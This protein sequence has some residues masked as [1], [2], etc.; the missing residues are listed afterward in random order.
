MRFV[1]PDNYV[2]SPS[3]PWF[4][5]FFVLN[6]MAAQVVEEQVLEHDPLV[7]V[8][9]LRGVTLEHGY[10]Y[11]NVSKLQNMLLETA[12]NAPE[13]EAKELYDVL[14]E[15]VEDIV[16]GRSSIANRLDTIKEAL[17][18]V[19]NQELET[20]HVVHGYK[21]PTLSKLC[22]CTPLAFL[23][24]NF[25]ARINSVYSEDKL[26]RQ[27][28]PPAALDALVDIV[29]W[30]H[31]RGIDMNP[32]YYFNCEIMADML[33][34]PLDSFT[35]VMRPRDGHLATLVQW[36]QVVDQFELFGMTLS[37]KA[38]QRMKTARSTLDPVFRAERA[39]QARQARLLQAA[40]V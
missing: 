23:F 6:T 40:P 37:S 17:A 13:N 25:H 19:S 26:R 32:G 8:E 36:V 14:H 34:C 7:L 24:G 12:Y 18:K 39:R 5:C 35:T 20:K 11:N 4:C 22:A 27:R 10:E 15:F 38:Q 3:L 30:F 2:L 1:T 29:S 21:L 31:Q 9:T 16:Y 33:R 28:V